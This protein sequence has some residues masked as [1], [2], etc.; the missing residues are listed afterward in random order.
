M[1][2]ILY[3]RQPSGRRQARLALQASDDVKVALAKDAPATLKEGTAAPVTLANIEQVEEKPSEHTTA[4]AEGEA[5][6]LE[7]AGAGGD[8]MDVDDKPA[9]SLSCCEIHTI[10]IWSQT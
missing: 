7:Q 6:G 5:A 10:T 3:G 1:A 9:R 8:A 4:P 2:Q